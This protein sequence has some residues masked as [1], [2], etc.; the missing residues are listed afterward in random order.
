MAVIVFWSPLLDRD[1]PLP[2]GKNQLGS[3]F[4][5]APPFA[6]SQPSNDCQNF[7]E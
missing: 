5:F 4:H 1:L 3:G 6:A 2:F 7:T